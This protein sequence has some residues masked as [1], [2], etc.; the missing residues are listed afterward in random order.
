MRFTAAP[1]RRIRLR[2][3]DVPVHL[4]AL[5]RFQVNKYLTV[6]PGVFVV[7]NPNGDSRNDP[8]VVYTIRTTLTF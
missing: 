5:Y 4:E 8:I 2:D 3:R 6:T 1:A 7:F